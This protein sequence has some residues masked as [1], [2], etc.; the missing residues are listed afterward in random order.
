MAYISFDEAWRNEFYNIVSA[1]YNL[2]VMNLNQF[3]HKVNDS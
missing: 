1:K 3:K 2:Q